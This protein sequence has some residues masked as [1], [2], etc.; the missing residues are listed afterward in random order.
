MLFCPLYCSQALEAMQQQLHDGGTQAALNLTPLQTEQD[1][2]TAAAGAAAAAGL[3]DEQQQQQEF[4][5][6]DAMD[7]G[8]GPDASAGDAYGGFP[9]FGAAAAAGQQ[10]AL[11]ESPGALI[12]TCLVL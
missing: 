10:A 5:G 1:T 3:E 4:G 9:G 11:Q 6:L 2:A 8:V 12:N 7:E